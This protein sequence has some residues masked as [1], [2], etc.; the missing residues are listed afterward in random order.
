[1]K[2]HYLPALRGLFGDWA[3]YSCLM[4]L[5][6]VAER[7]QFAAQIHKSKALSDLIQRELKEGRAKEISDYLTMNPTAFSTRWW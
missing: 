3:F 1:M 5:R 4:S 6:S 7:I 2:R